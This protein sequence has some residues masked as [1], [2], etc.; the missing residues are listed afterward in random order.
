ML[1]SLVLEPQ[2]VEEWMS[3]YFNINIERDSTCR[4]LSRN[5]VK[6]FSLFKLIL[7]ITFHQNGTFITLTLVQP[8]HSQQQAAVFSTKQHQDKVSY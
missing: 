5:S 2:L 6:L 8:H 4:A 3:E 1:T 7:L